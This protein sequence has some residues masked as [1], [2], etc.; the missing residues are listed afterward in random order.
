MTTGRCGLAT[1]SGLSLFKNEK[2]TGF[3]KKDGLLGGG[4]NFFHPNGKGAL[5][6]GGNERFIRFENGKFSPRAESMPV[7]F[8]SQSWSEDADGTL[9]VTTWGQG[10]NRFKDGKLT[11]YTTKDGLYDNTAWSVLDDG[12]GNLWIGGNRGIFRVAKQEL[13]DF[14]DGKIKSVT[15]VV[16]GTADGM[17]KRE[18][19]AGNPSALRARDGRLW[20]ATTGGAV[21]IDPK[22]IK[23]NRVP[24]PVVLEKVIGDERTVEPNEAGIELPAGT[25]NV[26]FHYVGLSFIAPERVKYKYKLDG[27]DKEWIDANTRHTAF[28]TNLPPRDDYQFKVVAANDDGVW[29][30]RGASLRFRILAPFWKTWWFYGLISAGVAGI[31]FSLFRRRV[32]RLERANAAQTAFSRRLIESQEQERKRIA[33]ELHDSLGQHLIIIKNW[34]SLGLRLSTTGAPASEQLEVIS[35]TALLA[36]SEVREIVHDLRPFQLETNGLTETIRLVA[37]SGIRFTVD[38]DGLENLFSPEDQVT[39]YRAVQECISNV[40]KHSDAKRAD[41]TIKREGRAVK[42]KISDDGKGF[43]PGTPANRDGG[44]FGLTGLNERIGMLG[45]VLEIQSTPGRGTTILINLETKI[46]DTVK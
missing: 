3:G 8:N 33:A 43:A 2:F 23:I 29:N 6:I 12:G 32:E 31:L 39:F 19:N 30:E 5:D 46:S 40:I 14:A 27:F 18:T 22:N 35:A 16:Y 7:E 28:Y 26:E 1:D 17:R 20:F 11:T 41:L 25:R 24:P 21:V 4:V 34:A 15:S 36:I 9:W 37:S 10:L 42:L 44:G 13:N 45:G 38:C